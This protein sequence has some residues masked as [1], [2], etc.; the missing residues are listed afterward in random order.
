MTKL[1]TLLKLTVILILFTVSVQ[2]QTTIP[3]YYQQA[4]FL[5]TSPGA[6]GNGLIGFVNPAN[7]NYLHG[8]E[9]RVIFSADHE[10]LSSVDRWGL[11]SGAKH[12]GFGM[13]CREGIKD[14]RVAFSGGSDAF[15]LGLGYGWSSGNLKDGIRDNLFTVGML[16]RPNR[17]V[18]IGVSSSFALHNEDREGIFDLAIRPLGTDFMTVFGDFSLQAKDRLDDAMW[19]AGAALQILPGIHVTG[20]YFDS[21]AITAGLIFNFGA[22]GIAAQA[23]LPEGNELGQVYYGFRFGAKEHNIFDSYFCHNKKY[24][25]MD[26]KGKVG[27]RKFGFF[28]EGKHTLTQ[29]LDDLKGVID[30]PTVAGVAINLSGIYISRELSWEVREKLKQVSNAGK[31]VVIFLDRG[32]MTEYHL[33]SV[34][35]K[36]ILDPEGL[37]QLEGYLMGRTFL[38]GTLEKIGIGFDEW[39]FFK[40]KSANEYLSRESMTDADREQRQGLIDDIYAVVRGDICKSRNLSEQ[41]FDELI[42]EAVILQPKQALAEGLVDTLARWIDIEKIVESIEGKKKSLIKSKKLAQN[43]FPRRNWGSTPK[44]AVV[45]GLGVC[46]ME[47]GINARKLEKVLT[48]LAKNNSI[49]AIVFRADSPGGDGLASDLVAEAMK[50]C[51]DKK[52]VIVTQGN[53]AASGGYWISMYADTIVAAPYTI[54]GSIGVIGGW[55]WNKELGDKLGMVSDFVKVGKHAD[56][57]FGIRLPL[58]G[59]QIPDRNLTAEERAKIEI[60]IKDFYKEFVAKV[61]T[62]RNMTVQAVGEIAQGRV[63][64]G[65]DGKEKGLVDVIGGL[66]SAIVLAK[67]A[68]GIAVDKEVDIVELPKLGL[69]NPQM[70]TPSL[71]GFK[72]P[73]EPEENYE[74]KYL[75]T[76]AKYPGQPLP[77]LSPDMYPAEK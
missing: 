47:Q 65:I 63:W 50:K 14:Y 2:A 46:D 17:F 49:K 59:L 53:V 44:I 3:D 19:S 4:D 26:L 58:I 28:D 9:T 66:E 74:L 45:Y 73:A 35:D 70:F 76:I 22:D 56:L 37:L 60:L 30:D 69:F 20:R 36:V 48:A 43:V 12:L 67:Q 40:Y 42:N 11:F 16:S 15:S 72:L 27:Y 41:K 55:L 38:K 18:S 21:E 8:F 57:G 23:N 39:R 68:A 61:A 1:S 75:K 51:A 24:L 62:G 52:P 10:N 54:T 31:R 7:L 32:G 77:L 5:F 34:A 6:L 25:H 13:I 29:I 71:F 33:A 64:S